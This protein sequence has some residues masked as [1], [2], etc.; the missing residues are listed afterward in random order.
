[1]TLEAAKG[2]LAVFSAQGLL[3]DEL[4][5]ALALFS[6][7][8]GTNWSFLLGWSGSRGNTAFAGGLL[9]ISWLSLLTLSAVVLL[10][11][12]ITGSMFLATRIRI[13]AQPFIIL[14]LTG[15]AIYGLMALAVS[16]IFLSKHRPE[17]DDHL[18][19][20]QRWHERLRTLLRRRR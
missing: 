3:G 17:T 18:Q 6:V 4:A 15:S 9:L 7:V 10:G 13:F 19:F 16:A 1:M 2:F 14:V 8:V 20:R 11:R 12:W 5:S